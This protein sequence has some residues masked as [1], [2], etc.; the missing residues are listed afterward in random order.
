MDPTCINATVL[1]CLEACYQSLQPHLCLRD[2]AAAL[3]E[4]P[5]WG[6]D[7]VRQFERAANRLLSELLDA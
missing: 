7:D 1:H 5:G 4:D 2:Y 3:R 6:E